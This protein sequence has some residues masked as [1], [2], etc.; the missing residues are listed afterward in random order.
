MQLTM[1]TKVDKC[2]Y[3]RIKTL[4]QIKD[5]IGKVNMGLAVWKKMFSKSKTDEPDTWIGKW[6]FSKSRN[7]NTN[8]K[9]SKGYEQAGSMQIK[10]SE[11]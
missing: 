1:S 10:N 3:K 8:G 2:D 7:R 6:N 5:V 11:G 9:T 4:V